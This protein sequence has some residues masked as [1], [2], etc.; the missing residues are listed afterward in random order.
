MG[1][2]GILLSSGGRSFQ[3]SMLEVR[4]D[5]AS[6]IRDWD[7]RIEASVWRGSGECGA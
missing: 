7:I 2:S 1:K 4:A 3:S 6:G 5:L